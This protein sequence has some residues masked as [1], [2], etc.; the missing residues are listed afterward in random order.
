M[1]LVYELVNEVVNSQESLISLVRHIAMWPSHVAH[2]RSFSLPS[3]F[4]HVQQ[5]DSD[6]PQGVRYGSHVW[7]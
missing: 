5:I 3:G 2:L 1:D 7:G 6:P 4:A